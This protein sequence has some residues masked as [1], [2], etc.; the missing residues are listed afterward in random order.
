MDNNS[1]TETTFRVVFSSLRR[2]KVKSLVF[3]LAVMTAV[4][5]WNAIGIKKYRSEGK[6]LVRVGR[7]NS[8]LDPTVTLG[9]DQV[10]SVPAFR[11]NELNSLVEVLNSSALAEKIVDNLGPH[12]I[13][14]NDPSSSGA[15][16][17]DP[18]E[19]PKD[20]ASW[21]DLVLSSV[22]NP[23]PDERQ[24]A[25]RRV[26]T[27]LEASSIPRSNIIRVTY[28]AGTPQA[29]Q[30]V[31]GKLMDLF[32]EEHARLQRPT[33][34]EGFLEAQTAHIHADLMQTE[35]AIRRLKSET[36]I[37]S[38]QERRTI[39]VKRVGALEDES[40]QTASQLAVAESAAKGLS[41]KLATIPATEIVGETQGISD[42][43][44][45]L[46]RDRFYA[47]QLAEQEARTRLDENHPR[48]QELLK[49]EKE[50]KEILDRQAE[51]RNQVTRAPN[52]AYE[53]L[54]LQLLNQEVA[55]ASLK[56]KA[57]KLGEQLAEA[58]RALN[59]FTDQEIRIV[60]LD[61]ERD[62]QEARYRK[63]SSV[64]EEA[65]VDQ[66]LQAQRMSNISVVQPASYDPTIILPRK[67]LN[68]AAGFAVGILGAI[69]I[70]LMAEARAPRSPASRN[71]QSAREPPTNGELV[72]H[73]PSD[74]ARMTVVNAP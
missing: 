3:F 27:S 63:Y 34:G 59:R 17:D 1:P 49:Q 73:V 7:E 31:L 13:L 47:V 50:A 22:T 43:G 37:A 51:T 72:G 67:S 29:S 69:G 71:P 2:H 52:K 65:R 33:G 20:G 64:T 66:A 38:P 4:L 11:D 19:K 10:L 70:A 23:Q 9:H 15:A 62:I 58:R 53:Q 41:E 12:V 39:V 21:K 35:E 61:R 60:Q 32:L 5:I 24:R 56:S 26:M 55:L 54:K 8:T 14:E 46:M 74:G 25:I 36:E 28:Q 45:N 30:A 57:G 6:L 68:L 44:T 16:P 40:L 18:A 42:G 48:M